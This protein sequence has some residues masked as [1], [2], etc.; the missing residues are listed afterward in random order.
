MLA[1]LRKIGHE[2]RE[3]CFPV[4]ADGFTAGLAKL[5]RSLFEG[6]PV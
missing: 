5:K 3:E 1:G 6:R 2:W 4:T